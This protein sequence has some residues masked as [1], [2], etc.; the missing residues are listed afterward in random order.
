VLSEH[1]RPVTGQSCRHITTA[2]IADGMIFLPSPPWLVVT[3]GGE[4]FN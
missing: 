1:A 2:A 4:L 3:A